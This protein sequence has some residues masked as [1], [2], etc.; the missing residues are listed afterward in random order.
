MRN[1][2]VRAEVERIMT[3]PKYLEDPNSAWVSVI[4][5]LCELVDRAVKD[6]ASKWKK[7]VLESSGQVIEESV[8][9]AKSEKRRIIK[10]LI[11]I[12]QSE[13]RKVTS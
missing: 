4:N 7:V 2:E 9:G 11:A 13:A 8:N 10:K 6:E 3:K 12:L 5:D 1:R